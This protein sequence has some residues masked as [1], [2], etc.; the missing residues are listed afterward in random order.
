MGIVPETKVQ[1]K[2]G[3]L[4]IPEFYNTVRTLDQTVDVDYYV[5]GCPPV[6]EQ[7]A[8][9]MSAVVAGSYRRI[10]IPITN[11]PGRYHLA[12]M[13]EAGCP[14]NRGGTSNLSSR[15]P[16]YLRGKGI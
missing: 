8:A 7:V 6:G 2:E 1:M 9:V 3:V 11:I 14:K 15:P 16:F 5:P 4:T 12:A 10:R 13:A